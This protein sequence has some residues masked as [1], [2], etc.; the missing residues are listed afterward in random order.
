M[1]SYFQI[2]CQQTLISQA[3]QALNLCSSTV[4][5]AGSTEEIEFERL[6]LI[7][8]TKLFLCYVTVFKNK[9]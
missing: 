3:S 5:F 6:L 9:Y 7:A 4:E 8:S 2:S 1:F